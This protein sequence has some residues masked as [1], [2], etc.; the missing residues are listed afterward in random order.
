MSSIV[1]FDWARMIDDLQTVAGMTLDEIADSN[2]Y[3]R[4]SRSLLRYYAEG[5]QPTF[6]RGYALLGLWCERMGN[7]ETQAPIVQWTPSHRVDDGRT[8]TLR[9]K[10]PTCQRTIR[11]VPIA[12]WRQLD[13]DPRQ[14]TLEDVW[15]APPVVGP[16]QGAN[17]LREA[18]I[19]DR[20]R[21]RRSKPPKDAA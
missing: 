17:V 7:D 5:G 1:S 6:P 15:K 20:R 9:P 12:Q 11:G 3:L 14:V 21:S 10:C 13:I 2:E 8:M 4:L 18:G 16:L 19:G